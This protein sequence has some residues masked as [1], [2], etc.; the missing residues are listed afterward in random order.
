[1]ITLDEDRRTHPRIALQRPCKVC[2]PRSGKYYA[3]HTCDLSEGGMLIS[4]AQR[5]NIKPGDVL[6]VGVAQKR[7]QVLLRTNEMVRLRVTRCFG[8][9]DGHWLIGLELLDAVDTDERMLRRA[10]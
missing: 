10:A 6:H 8:T 4:I 1:M 5:M 3:G 9:P 7:R 2:E